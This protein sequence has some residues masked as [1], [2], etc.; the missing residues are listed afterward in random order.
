MLI[1]D[2]AF[3]GG[4]SADHP[5]RGFFVVINLCRV[6][7][8]ARTDKVKVALD[9]QRHQQPSRRIQNHRDR[10]DEAVQVVLRTDDNDKALST[11]K[12]AGASIL[13]EADIR[14]K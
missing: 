12:A 6:S 11:L 13:T 3:G 9:S 10:D 7:R 4:G 2:H 5:A 14:K 1:D 8:R